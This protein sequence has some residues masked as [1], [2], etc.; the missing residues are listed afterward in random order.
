MKPS[1]LTRL[2]AWGNRPA[3][4]RD[5]LNMLMIAMASVAIGAI[6][7]AVIMTARGAEC[8]EQ[9]GCPYIP[10][11]VAAP[12]ACNAACPACEDVGGGRG[13]CKAIGR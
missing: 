7:L 4:G 6:F 2:I 9:G 12:S 13:R 5:L 3:D 11:H 1:R 10:C 8:S